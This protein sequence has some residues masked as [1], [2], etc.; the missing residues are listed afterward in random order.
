LL[1][2]PLG[3]LDAK[4]RKL[5]QVE[6]K[7]L[8]ERVGITFLYV[9]HDQEE[10]LTMSDRLAV[11]EAGSI[12]QVGT[13]RDVYESPTHAF[14]ADFL[15]AANLLDAVALGRDQDGRC[16]VRLG[17]RELRAGGGALDAR[18]AVRLVIRPERVV[19]E[20]A[21][22]AA[23]RENCLPGVVERLVFQGP[24]TQILLR[25][26]GGEQ[27]QSMMPN[28][29]QDALLPAGADV[30]VH[31]PPA[32]LRVLETDDSHAETETVGS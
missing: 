32:A 2:E 22:A 7:A 11:M 12:R 29:G 25:L 27:L 8:Q 3:A 13:A 4:L 23:T 20:P 14:V 26:R 15:G 16:R 24:V 10:A 30:S 21:A 17:D 5:L 31:L 6:L 18:G 28:Q 19:L 9:T 1:D